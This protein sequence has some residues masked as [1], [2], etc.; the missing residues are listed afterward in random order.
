MKTLIKRDD[1]F[2]AET[3]EQR[4]EYLKEIRRCEF[5]L[6]AI[7]RTFWEQTASLI[8]STGGSYTGFTR[9][10]LCEEKNSWFGVQLG[11]NGLET[12]YVPYSPFQEYFPSNS[13][14]YSVSADE[15]LEAL[16]LTQEKIIKDIKE[17]IPSVKLS[18]EEL[19][20]F[21][22][23]FELVRQFP[24]IASISIERDFELEYWDGD[25]YYKF[26]TPCFYVNGEES[27]CKIRMRESGIVYEESDNIDD[28]E[29]TPRDIRILI[30]NLHSH[31][32]NDFW[33]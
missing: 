18:N 16:K 26:F 9:S 32:F 17:L 11:E 31:Y 3:E 27:H 4:E 22:Y 23:L 30:H 2:P 19:K 7:K 6:S 15:Y 14:L 10:F 12:F 25:D 29:L 20:M 8:G 33:N 24:M 13:P 5:N 21:D 28:K 1:L